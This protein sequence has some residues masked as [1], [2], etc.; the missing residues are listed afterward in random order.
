MVVDYIKMNNFP[1][2]KLFKFQMDFELKI[3]EQ[4]KFEFSLNFKRVQTFW[5]N[6]INLPKIFLYLIF[7]NMNLD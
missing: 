7:K 3:Q 1:F 5:E 2:G 4:N 6:S